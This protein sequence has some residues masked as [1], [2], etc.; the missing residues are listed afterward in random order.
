M[1]ERERERVY[2]S[3]GW[4]IPGS[5]NETEWRE[6]CVNLETPVRLIERRLESISFPSPGFLRRET[7]SYASEIYLKPTRNHL[8]GNSDVIHPP[9]TL[10]S[11]PR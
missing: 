2:E 6:R 9:E 5:G 1:S 3:G 4:S 10:E 7:V 11:N 8:L